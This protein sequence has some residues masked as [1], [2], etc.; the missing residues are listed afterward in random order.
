[1]HYFRKVSIELDPRLYSD[2]MVE[3]TCFQRGNHDAHKLEVSRAGHTPHSVRIKLQPSHVVERYV[4]SDALRSAL[5]AFVANPHAQSFTKPDVLLAVWEYIKRRNL[6]KEDD[7]R[8]A[9]C[10][11]TLRQLFQCDSLPFTSIVVALKPHL[12][13][14]PP[15]DVEYQLSLELPTDAKPET[16]LDEKVVLVDV[17]HVDEVERARELA[18]QAWDE[19]QQEQ[20][21]ELA[22]LERQEALLLSQLDACHRKHE[23][24]QQFAHDPAGFIADVAASQQS[25]M[26]ILTSEAE[27][28]EIN[29]PHANQ[30]S[31]PWVREVVADLLIPP[32]AN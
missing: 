18:L 9:I 6:I 5:A 32:P 14:A 1:V 22:L 20:Q 15:L 17:G 10:D 12:T 3:W 2:A 11:A 29:V 13:P 31:Q 16:P 8:V 7:C 24:L 25:D 26:E 27:T 21:K 4:L 19:L 28:D 30:F 23:W